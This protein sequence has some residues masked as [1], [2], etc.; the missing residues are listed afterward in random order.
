MGSL[1][2]LKYVLLGST[3]YSTSLDMWGVG[4]IFVEMVTG[5]PTF[6]GIR[7]TYD[8]L[9]KIFKLLGTPTEETWPG[10][11][12]FPGYKPHKLGFYRPRKLGH[13]F[14]RLYDIVDGET[15]ANAFLQ[16][17]PEQRVGAEEA[18]QHPYFAPLPRK[19]YELPDEHY[20]LIANLN[21]HNHCH[22]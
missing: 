13:N 5:M 9:D 16:L 20:K 17:N 3:E 6:P 22:R 1:E 4:C 12:H 8:Q 11:T 21:R 7:D 14:P 2:S 19:L 15:I 18:L 10:V